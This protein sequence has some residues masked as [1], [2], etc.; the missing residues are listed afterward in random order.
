MPS[1]VH[2]PIDPQA[3]RTFTTVARIGNIT[4]A[5]QCL[6]RSQPAISLQ[7]KN[8][9]EATGLKLFHR[10][11]QGMVL[12]SEGA[13][14]LPL[15]DKVLNALT[16]FSSAVAALHTT[17]REQLR[18]GTILDP[19]FTRIGSFLLSLAKSFP[20]IETTLQQ[21]VSGEVLARV[22]RGE[23]DVGFYLNPP[24]ALASK[25]I[26][27]KTLTRFVYRVLAPAGWE[28][29][30]RGKDWATLATLPWIATPPSSVH[31]RLQRRVFGP[32]SLTGLE[33]HR[34]ALVDQEPSML[35]LVRSGMGLSLVRDSIAT[36]ESQTRGL[37][38]A[39]QV[40]LE[41]ELSFVCRAERA[42]EPAITA[43]FDTVGKIW[44]ST[45][46]AVLAQGGL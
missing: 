35:D 21:E 16:E 18:I 25:S 24:D 37:V 7:I 28:D 46:K 10:T 2:L 19:E 17:A 11:H 38:I 9:N 45:A 27:R 13:A 41:C 30:V 4:R 8:L 34:V 3:L 33:P 32:D 1:P 22:E 42:T 14:L 43:A 6:H 23:L 36:H 40:S 44:N 5:A 20:Q 26:I 15:A 29:K 39:D 12:T 31:H